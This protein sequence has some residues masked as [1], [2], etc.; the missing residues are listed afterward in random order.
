MSKHLCTL[1][2]EF[3]RVFFLGGELSA[4]PNDT[5]VRITMKES[6]GEKIHY[7]IVTK[8]GKEVLPPVRL[9]GIKVPPDTGENRFAKFIAVSLAES[10]IS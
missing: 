1:Y 4:D 2:D 10:L 8:N 5:S 7:L 3:H 6:G 9:A